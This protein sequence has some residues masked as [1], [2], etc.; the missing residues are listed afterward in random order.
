[1]TSKTVGLIEPRLVGGTTDFIEPSDCRERNVKL[2]GELQHACSDEQFAGFKQSSGSM[3][4]GDMSPQVFFA[5]C[6]E[7]LG[8]KLGSVFPELVVLLPNISIQQELLV[9]PQRSLH[10][11]RETNI[12]S[13]AAG[14]LSR[15]PGIKNT[16]EMRRQGVRL[17]SST[18]SLD[19]S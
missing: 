10:C 18:R 5:R 3:R 8:T 4:N 19:K 11:F 2:I 17:L 9:R 1:M 6:V 15:V 16:L 13:S 14:M 7:V 12:K